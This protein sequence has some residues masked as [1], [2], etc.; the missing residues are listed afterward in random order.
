MSLGEEFGSLSGRFDLPATMAF[1]SP[2][3]YWYG[4]R[5][6]VARRLPHLPAKPAFSR[7][8]GVNRPS[9]VGQAQLRSG[10]TWPWFLFLLPF[11][12]AWVCVRPP[13]CSAPHFC[14]CSQTALAGFGGIL[15]QAVHGPEILQGTIHKWSPSGHYSPSLQGCLWWETS[16]SSWLSVVC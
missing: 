11:S 6:F 3:A 1:F 13:Q 12:G 9:S 14:T 8:P 16:L 7:F 2:A 10:Q 5:W 15:L 4:T